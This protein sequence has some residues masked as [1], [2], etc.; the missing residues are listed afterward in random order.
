MIYQIHHISREVPLMVIRR[1]RVDND[2]KESLWN[3]IELFDINQMPTGHSKA[4]CDGVP[5]FIPS[6]RLKDLFQ[7][8]REGHYKIEYLIN[9]S[10]S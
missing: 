5:Y 10:E 7:L 4:K 3:V 9:F 1:I 6:D 2:I 8:V